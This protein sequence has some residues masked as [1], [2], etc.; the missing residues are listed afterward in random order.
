MFLLFTC[1][2]SHLGICKHECYRPRDG[3]TQ[4]KTPLV[5]HR[6]EKKP[7]KPSKGWLMYQ[8]RKKLKKQEN[9]AGVEGEPSKEGD[10]NK[11]GGN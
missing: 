9:P 5:Y 4:R 8:R 1:L 10:T 7:K 6:R 2:S 11:E 3:K